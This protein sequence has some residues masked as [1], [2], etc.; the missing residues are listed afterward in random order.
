MNPEYCLLPV[1]RLSDQTPL[2]APGRTQTRVDLSAVQARC[3]EH[4]S[5]GQFYRSCD[6]DYQN[7]FQALQDGWGRGAG[8][9]VLSKV[10]YGHTEKR[11][12]HLRSCA[13]LDVCLHAPYWYIASVSSYAIRTM[14]FDMMRTT[15]P[16]NQLRAEIFE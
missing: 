2:C 16:A 10:A 5:A 11:S 12:V 3:D 15:V 13:W 4:V 1:G 7:E 6:N 14:E 8:V 9:E